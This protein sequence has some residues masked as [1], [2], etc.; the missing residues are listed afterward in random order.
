MAHF[1]EAKSNKKNQCSYLNNAIRKYGEHAF[2]V[3]LL[4]TC[5]ADEANDKEALYI[6]MLQT[7]APNGYNLLPMSHACSP[8]DSL[9][10]RIAATLRTQSLESKLTRFSGIDLNMEQM[11]KYIRPLRKHGNQYG[12]YVYIEGRKADFGGVALSLEQSYQD[13]LAFIQILSNKRQDVLLRETPKASATTNVGK[14][15]DGP[16]LMAVPNGKSAEDVT[17]GNP[18][19]YSLSATQLVA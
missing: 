10:Q 7:L 8:S 17:M 12:Y 2:Q 11:H 1:S 3:S 19:A 4:N 9:R 14:L 5:T 6:G 16:R 15:T 13:A 18:Q